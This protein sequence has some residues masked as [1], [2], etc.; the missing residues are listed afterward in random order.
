MNLFFSFLVEDARW[1]TLMMS[2]YRN[3]S[4]QEGDK[5]VGS[6]KQNHWNECQPLEQCINLTGN[7][8]TNCLSSYWSSAHARCEWE[9][10]RFSRAIQ[11]MRAV[12][13]T[14][15]TS[16]IC[17]PAAEG[18]K[19]LFELSRRV[20]ASKPDANGRQTPPKFHRTRLMA[21][22]TSN[23]RGRIHMVTV[24]K[25]TSKPK[26]H[27]TARWPG[28]Q[29]PFRTFEEKL[30]EEEFNAQL[31]PSVTEVF[32]GQPAEIHS[33]STRFGIKR[34]RSASRRLFEPS[35]SL[36]RGCKVSPHTQRGTR[37]ESNDSLSRDLSNLP[38]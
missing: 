24:A 7:S 16:L 31:S 2:R 32:T 1:V 21:K 6:I 15:K 20:R 35:R 9:R 12:R 5:F 19:V 30:E 29:A 11:P 4:A 33:K 37:S 22:R 8:F 13:Q 34:L 38:G 28:K 25:S 3:R 23:F 14:T 36:F 27:M 26:F 17:S 10:V 18:G